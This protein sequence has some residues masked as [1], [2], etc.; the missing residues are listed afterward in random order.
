MQNE[1]FF[2]F[3]HI[4]IFTSFVMSEYKINLIINDI[5][6]GT[7]FGYALENYNLFDTNKIKEN[8]LYI[9]DVYQT[10]FYVYFQQIVT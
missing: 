2:F 1:F 6:F 5:N 7:R 3:N 10:I 8:L 9:H 4:L